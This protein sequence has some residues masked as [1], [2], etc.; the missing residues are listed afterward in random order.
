M[1]SSNYTNHSG[2]VTEKKSSI[3][4]FSTTSVTSKKSSLSRRSSRHL[5]PP[6][7]APSFTTS[8][9]TKQSQQCSCA[10]G[11]YDRNIYTLLYINPETEQRFFDYLFVGSPFLGGKLAFF[12]MTFTLL[13]LYIP[14]HY[15]HADHTSEWLH[16]EDI[17]PLFMALYGLVGLILSFVPSFDRYR[18]SFCFVGILLHIPC[19][20]WYEWRHKVPER[21]MFGYVM[22]Y[23]FCAALVSGVRYARLALVIPVGHIASFMAVTFVREEPLRYWTEEY[24]WM[25]ALWWPVVVLP[26][27]LQYYL[28]RYTRQA[29][30]IIDRSER[31]LSGMQQ[32]LDS[33]KT[34]VVS[35]FPRTVTSE[36]VKLADEHVLGSPSSARRKNSSNEITFSHHPTGAVKFDFPE[37][38]IIVTDI[39]GFTGW[40]AR[41]DNNF[42]VEL[43]ADMFST[44]DTL[45][46]RN[47][48]EKVTTV[49]DSFVGMVFGGKSSP[50]PAPLRC[51]H[52][53]LFGLDIHTMLGFSASLGLRHRVGIHFGDVVGGFVGLSPPRFDVFGEAVDHAKSLESLCVVGKVHASKD[54]I[55]EIV[56]EPACGVPLDGIDTP[57]GVV[58]TTWAGGFLGRQATTGTV[59]VDGD[60][61]NEA[62]L[63]S[64]E[65]EKVLRSILAL[66]ET[67]EEI[68]KVDDAATAG[69]GAETSSVT[70]PHDTQEL[71]RMHIAFLHFF[72]EEIERVYKAS[73]RLR[74][75]ESQ[76]LMIM[77]LLGALTL[78][79]HFMSACMDTTGDHIYF[80]VTV[81]GLVLFFSFQAFSDHSSDDHPKQLGLISFLAFLAPV[82]SSTFLSTPCENYG[83]SEHVRATRL[84]NV[85]MAHST[86][87]M[88]VCQFVN[89]LPISH[90]I[91]AMISVQVFIVLQVPLR[92]WVIGDDV[93]KYDIMVASGPAAFSAI[94]YLSE[95]SLRKA[96]VAQQIIWEALQST[97][98]HAKETRRVLDVML[99]AF[100][101]EKL[102][103]KLEAAASNNNNNNNSTI[104][105]PQSSDL[106]SKNKRNSMPTDALTIVEVI[107][108][109]SVSSRSTAQKRLF[110]DAVSETPNLITSTE[111]RNGKN[112]ER[113][114]TKLYCDGVSST[115]TGSS[116]RS[117]SYLAQQQQQQVQQPPETT[118][119]SKTAFSV[120]PS[121][122]D[123]DEAKKE[124]NN[125]NERG[126]IWQYPSVCA[127]FLCFQTRHHHNHNPS[128]APDTTN[129][130]FVKSMMES[131][132]RCLSR[133]KV[134]KVKTVGT[135]M[136]CV[137][138]VEQ[139]GLDGESAVARA[140]TA[141]ANVVR[142][143]LSRDDLT[144]SIGYTWSV[145]LHCGP[146]FGAVL[147]V[148]G[149]TFDVFGDTINTASRMMTTA[150]RN[151]VQLSSKVVEWLGGAAHTTSTDGAPATTSLPP[152]TSL[153]A[154]DPISVKGKGTMNVYR[155]EVEAVKNDSVVR[156]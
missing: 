72:N 30:E 64:D 50:I 88:F 23:N 82:I 139:N 93:Y 155:M 33:L 70:A 60:D 128:S 55:E 87:G 105:Q 111:K 94:S 71:Y 20:D 118:C 76:L 54:V 90:K 6:S 98:R 153:E 51:M 119:I 146:C 100:V 59:A 127:M 74:D 125:K 77:A 137:C 141:T 149:L 102:I 123:V 85:I 84:S 12:S 140:V 17:F 114:A 25:E 45:A 28:E 36:I 38:V 18:E 122:S 31:E 75:G 80:V 67:A 145:G 1:S 73:V 156:F 63:S 107:T 56:S 142:E 44:M 2:A 143:V 126:L 34:T 42:V 8:N 109:T 147:G 57:E 86:V 129:F 11:P 116:T 89:D 15:V 48:V 99:P 40:T 110:D 144:Q 14:Y 121:S 68:N 101:S 135:T 29:F 16:G 66:G 124:N 35:F 104:V 32:R 47:H 39:A 3:V 27:A 4:K 46:Q 26:V 108:T 113:N 10:V 95:W 106:L 65:R 97:G 78:V 9:N 150:E 115:S 132:E 136:F 92:E 13:I 112:N 131:I 49:G 37:S 22:A 53:C 61:D 43:L 24:T 152:H 7:A 96:F 133:D 21:S 120:S 69:K 83:S 41:T 79:I 134:L 130:D 138:G 117:Q 5:L 154:L 91:T 151:S 19:F 62:L 81:A 58:F 103:K 148:R 52:A